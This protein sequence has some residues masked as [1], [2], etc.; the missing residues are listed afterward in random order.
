LLL[1]GATPIIPMILTGMTVPF[2]EML[3]NGDGA[4]KSEASAHSVVPQK[5]W[6]AESA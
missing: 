2:A 6:T 5:G 4:V 3:A 1:G